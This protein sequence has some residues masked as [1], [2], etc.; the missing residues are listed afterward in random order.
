MPGLEVFNYALTGTG[1]DQ[2]YLT[3]LDCADVDHDLVI[4][5]LFVENIGRVAHR[6]LEFQDEHGKEVFYAKPYYE[7]EKGALVLRSVPVPKQPWTRLTLP[8]EDAS[9]VDRGAGIFPGVQAVLRQVV[10]LPLLR[11]AVEKLGVRELVQ[12]VTKFQTVPDYDAPDNP[13]WRLLSTILETWIRGSR[14]PV[15]LV[16]IPNWTFIEASG[17][18]TGYQ[19]RF[20][21]LADATGCHLHDPLPDFWKYSAEE[22][23]AFRFP[24]DTHLSARGHQAMARSLAPV[25]ARIMR[26]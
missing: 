18:P 10:P 13:R 22:R 8:P 3:Y 21:E 4:I 12:K 26:G 24:R 11:S 5:G 9:Q 20:R 15:L 16:P 2:Q 6:Y 14:T 19:T 23:R 17:D 1:S 25:V 7:I